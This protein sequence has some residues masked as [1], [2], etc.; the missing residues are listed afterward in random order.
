M[1][2][3]EV[4]GKSN[5]YLGYILVVDQGGNWLRYKLRPA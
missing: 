2:G 3:K 1:E 5:E 4:G